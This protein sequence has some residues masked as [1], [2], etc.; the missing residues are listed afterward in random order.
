MKDKETTVEEIKEVMSV[1]TKERDWEQFHSPKD[2][3]I[4]LS[5]EVSEVLE[6]FRFKQDAEIAEWMKDPKNK[7]DLQDELGDCIGF[8]AELARVTDIDLA[9][10]FEEKMAKTRKKYPAD[11]VKGKNHKYTYYE[12]NSTTLD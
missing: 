8:L 7:Q 11:V 6:Y 5:I 3:T 1:F 9:K 2:V 4:A 10:A 12:K